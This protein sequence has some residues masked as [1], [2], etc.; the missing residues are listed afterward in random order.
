MRYA[1][2][3]HTKALETFLVDCVLRLLQLAV[4]SWRDISCMTRQ[5]T[6]HDIFGM[7]DSL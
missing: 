7:Y 4:G 2:T 3:A 1:F 5:V 6:Q